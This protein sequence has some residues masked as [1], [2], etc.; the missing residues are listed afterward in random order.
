[1]AS[2]RA[3]EFR[4]RLARWEEEYNADPKKTE[5]T[6]V[7]ISTLRAMIAEVEHHECVLHRVEEKVVDFLDS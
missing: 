2:S 6:P 4:N 7:H 5:I 1:M 3:E